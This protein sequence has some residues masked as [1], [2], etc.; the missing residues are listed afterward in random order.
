MLLSDRTSFY[1]YDL[2]TDSLKALSLPINMRVRSIVNHLGRIWFA[3][4]DGLYVLNPT[5]NSVV[6]NGVEQGL[7]MP[8]V[9]A[10][11]PDKDRLWIGFGK[12]ANGTSVG[13]L[14]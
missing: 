4:A 10:L 6:T 12:T 8:G 11:Q 5:D 3:T 7:L 14:G 13:G 9:T 2:S 1:R